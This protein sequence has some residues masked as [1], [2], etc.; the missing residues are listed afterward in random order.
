[1][2]CTLN[3]ALRTLYS[4]PEPNLSYL[5]RLDIRNLYADLSYSTYLHH[6]PEHEILV[7]T[8]PRECTAIINLTNNHGCKMVYYTNVDG[9]LKEIEITSDRVIEVDST[10]SITIYTRSKPDLVISFRMILSKFRSKL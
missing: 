3:H 4:M 7:L 2:I 8:F 5:Q 6:R 1:M 10:T 9:F